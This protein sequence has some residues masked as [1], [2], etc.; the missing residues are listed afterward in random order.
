MRFIANLLHYGSIGAAIILSMGYAFE[1]ISPMGWLLSLSVCLNFNLMGRIAI[2]E[3]IREKLI[4]KN[5]GNK[6]VK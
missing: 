2:L 4:H 3:I 6:H 5:G 1:C